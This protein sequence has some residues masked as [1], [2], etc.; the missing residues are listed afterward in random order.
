[1]NP[2]NH[3]D[4]R[5]YIR[6]RLYLHVSKYNGEQVKK[7]TFSE[8]GIKKKFIFITLTVATSLVTSVKTN[9]KYHLHHRKID[10]TLFT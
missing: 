3:R 1:M 7:I 10:D 5:I 8:E 6:V 9:V 4:N 2:E